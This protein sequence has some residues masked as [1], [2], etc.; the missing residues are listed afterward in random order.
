MLIDRKKISYKDSFIPAIE[1]KNESPKAKILVIHGFGGSKEEQLG[2]GFRIAEANYDVL[3]IDL[4]GHGE[5]EL[6]FGTDELNYVNYAIK[7]LDCDKICAIGHSVGGRLAL[8]SQ[9]N[10][11]IGVSPTLIKEF[12][13]QTINIIR[14]LRDYHVKLYERD[15]LWNLQKALPLAIP[16]AKNEFCLIYGERDVPEIIQC[17]QNFKNGEAIKIPNAFHS[18][19][20]VNQI[21]FNAV[22]NK[23]DEW[24][25]L[26]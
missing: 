1:I 7:Y 23:L 16:E 26:H 18:D 17:C 12:S 15:A 11:S 13:D 14:N 20:F 2:L 25:D 24:F 4:P 6:L 21:V 8:I 22:V 3:L 10:Y 19:I 5:S 9:S